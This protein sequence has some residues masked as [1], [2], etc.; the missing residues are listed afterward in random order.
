MPAVRRR[1]GSQVAVMATAILLLML[2]S[3]GVDWTAWPRALSARISRLDVGSFPLPTQASQALSPLRHWRL[4]DR[5]RCCYSRDVRES[6]GSL[7]SS[8]AVPMKELSTSF[9]M[10]YVEHGR[11]GL[12]AQA[13]PNHTKRGRDTGCAGTVDL[14]ISMATTEQ[15]H[16]ALRQC[17]RGLPSRDGDSD[18]ETASLEARHP[19]STHTEVEVGTRP[20]PSAWHSYRPEGWSPKC[21]DESTHLKSALSD[22]LVVCDAHLASP[23][24]NLESCIAAITIRLLGQLPPCLVDQSQRLLPRLLRRW[25]LENQWRV[26]KRGMMYLCG[27][28]LLVL[29]L[30][31]VTAASWHQKTP[32]R[33]P[34]PVPTSS[35]SEHLA[36]ATA[37]SGTTTQVRRES[38]ALPF[39]DIFTDHVVTEEASADE[40]EEVRRAAGWGPSAPERGP[41]PHAQADGAEDPP[42]SPALVARWLARLSPWAKTTKKRAAAST[43][44]DSGPDPSPG[45]TPANPPRWPMKNA[46][47][48]AREN[49]LA[50]HAE[51]RAGGVFV[52]PPAP[53][54]RI[55]AYRDRRA[56]AALPFGIVH[57][58]SASAGSRTAA[59][60]APVPLKPLVASSRAGGEQEG[61]SASASASA[62]RRVP[63]ARISSNRS[64]D[65]GVEAGPRAISTGSNA[66]AAAAAAAVMGGPAPAIENVAKRDG[67]GEGA[68]AGGGVR[69]TS[70]GL[71]RSEH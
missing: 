50:D 34:P 33:A 60:Q 64:E 23:T 68:D 66:G 4:P 49:N 42:S 61:R 43:T 1:F 25:R 13:D 30:G 71:R 9:A 11:A 48:R 47:R 15:G 57:A 40:I 37:L 63:L 53:N 5:E 65:A 69:K 67:S 44:N 27:I 51:D 22:H 56:A 35:A 38:L 10:C 54:S 26:D 32:R 70:A 46:R 8:A 7:V 58:R 14:F 2:W 19:L 52:M 12:L 16:A 28:I 24:A 17:A 62:S 45:L 41:P 20:S 21:I 3:M 55:Q 59:A 6:T 29:V 31:I 39:R 36:P 18:P